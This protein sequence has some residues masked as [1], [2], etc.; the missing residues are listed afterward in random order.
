MKITCL[1]HPIDLHRFYMSVQKLTNR[2]CNSLEAACEALSKWGD[3][4][5]VTA[6]FTV[7]GDAIELKSSGN[8]AIFVEGHLY[9][10]VFVEWV[11]QIL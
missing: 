2:P 6:M 8:F 11:H 5:E 7:K 9:P 1:I 4:Y 3:Q 10:E